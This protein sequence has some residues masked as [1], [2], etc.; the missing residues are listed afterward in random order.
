[1]INKNLYRG[2]IF[3]FILV[4]LSVVLS[5]TAQITY[6]VLT[7]RLSL[8][9]NVIVIL[10]ILAPSFF[11]L[12][13]LL[14]F[15]KDV[16][17]Y[18]N[19]PLDKIAEE[20]LIS[21]YFFKI[22]HHSALVASWYLL[23]V[24]SFN[25]YLLLFQG[26]SLELG[27]IAVTG[28]LVIFIPINIV[29]FYLKSLFKKW[30]EVELKDSSVSRKVIGLLVVIPFF[31]LFFQQVVSSPFVIV[32]SIKSMES[33]VKQLT[34]KSKILSNLN[35]DSEIKRECQ[36][37][38][39][40]SSF[41][42]VLMRQ[43]VES[44][45]YESGVNNY[46]DILRKCI[47]YR[48]INFSVLKAEEVVMEY[49][50]KK[51]VKLD[52]SSNGIDI[53][54]YFNN[55]SYVHVVLE[56][57]E[58]GSYPDGTKHVGKGNSGTGWVTGVSND[59]NYRVTFGDLD[60][61]TCTVDELHY[62]GGVCPALVTIEPGRYKVYLE[63]WGLKSNELEITVACPQGG[64]CSPKDP[65]IV[66]DCEKFLPESDFK[67]GLLSASYIGFQYARATSTY[68]KVINNCVDY[69]ASVPTLLKVE[70]GSYKELYVGA[71]PFKTVY[72]DFSAKGIDS[73][74]SFALVL[75]NMSGDPK[76]QGIKH[77]T[78]VGNDLMTKNGDRYSLIFGPIDPPN[79][80]C[81]MDWLLSERF[82]SPSWSCP[83]NILYPGKY[84]AYLEKWGLKSNELE[85]TIQ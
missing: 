68:R 12:T 74:E 52:I 14:S 57:I 25:A 48:T 82:R 17:N 59:V 45:K 23:A 11:V 62:V 30:Q 9:E 38:L 35:T 15:I 40:Q 42:I 16:K 51:T 4:L 36:K 66:A 5:L 63:M 77:V 44:Q 85:I 54:N 76:S 46:N 50:S 3:V 8:D 27:A 33:Y 10:M 71:Q 32:Q 20:K 58:G 21:S 83:S 13:P 1:M 39:P 18:I 7:K 84:K 79:W 47:E 41:D 78:M 6:S 37:L 60:T 29:L 53:F 43:Y 2:L 81:S 80:Q 19:L 26:S 56:N 75:E 22:A 72:F 65:K 61:D 73:K 67:S 64:D 49:S 31:L 34:L 24:N 28:A 69:Q 55:G 70:Q